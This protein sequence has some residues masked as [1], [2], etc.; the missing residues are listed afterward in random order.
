[1]QQL[2][3]RGYGPGGAVFSN[4]LAV[5]SMILGIVSIL[6]A[7]LSSCVCFL[8][9]PLPVVAIVLGHIAYG[10]ARRGEASGAGMA[11]TG[12][13]CGYIALAMIAGVIL[14]F[15]IAGSR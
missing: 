7:V 14:F 4:N 6:G 8:T 3:Y 11:M 12:F 15:V 13:I 2:G 5:V 10:R 9:A 1:V